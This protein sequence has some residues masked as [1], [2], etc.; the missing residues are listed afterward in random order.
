MTRTRTYGRQAIS[1][2]R[3]PVIWRRCIA[4]SFTYGEKEGENNV[5]LE[6]ERRGRRKREREVTSIVTAMMQL[7]LRP[8]YSRRSRTRWREAGENRGGRKEK[9]R[10]GSLFTRQRTAIN[11]RDHCYLFIILLNVDRVEAPRPHRALYNA[12]GYYSEILRRLMR[13]AW[14]AREINERRVYSCA[15]NTQ[16]CVRSLC[17]HNWEIYIFFVKKY[18][19]IFMLS[20]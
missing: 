7:Q 20:I 12:R 18:D 10:P 17:I 1:R 8:S 6:K 11:P 9:E 5:G 13:G 2:H 14:A 4:A 19:R 15:A 16:M 3:S